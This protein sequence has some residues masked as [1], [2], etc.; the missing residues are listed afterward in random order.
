MLSPD[1]PGATPLLA[2]YGDTFDAVEGHLLVLALAILRRVVIAKLCLVLGQGKEVVV[3]RDQLGLE[4]GGLL[5]YG[6]LD[7]T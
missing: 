4:P 1:A 2:W 7:S 3:R 6:L 5:H